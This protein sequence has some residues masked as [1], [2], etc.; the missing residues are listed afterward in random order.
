MRD[1][2]H[3][4]SRKVNLIKNHISYGSL[5]KEFMLF[6]PADMLFRLGVQQLKTDGLLSECNL[7]TVSSLSGHRDD[8]SQ[9]VCKRFLAF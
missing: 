1:Q 6:I 3:A 7:S 9:K 8:L 2:L 4:K 5:I